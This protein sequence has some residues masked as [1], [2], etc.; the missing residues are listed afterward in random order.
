MSECQVDLS[1]RVK[2]AGLAKIALFLCYYFED[3]EFIQLEASIEACLLISFV[4]IQR[5]KYLDM[6]PRLVGGSVV[7]IKT[8]FAPLSK[9]YLAHV[10]NVPYKTTRWTIVIVF[11]YF[12]EE[13]ENI[14]TE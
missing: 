14:K 11:I 7:F 6:E 12:S 1:C 10:T 4:W 5:K 9:L 8:C 2:Q 3:Q 13:A